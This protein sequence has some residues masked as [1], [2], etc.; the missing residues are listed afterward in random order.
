[1]AG[2]GRAW[3]GRKV[4]GQCKGRCNTEPLQSMAKGMVD[5]RTWAVRQ[6]GRPGEGSG[7]GTA[8]DEAGCWASNYKLQ[9]SAGQEAEQGSVKRG[10]GHC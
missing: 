8:V 9:D 1:M 3:Q 10:G 6:N 7:H 5:C 2:Q 4:R